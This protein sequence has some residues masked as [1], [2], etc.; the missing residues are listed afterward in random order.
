MS[1]AKELLEMLSYINEKSIRFKSAKLIN[2]L[3]K[4]D[5][6]ESKFLKDFGKKYTYFK[7]SYSE[8]KEG[9]E[10]FEEYRNFFRDTEKRRT[11]LLKSQLG[12]VQKEVSDVLSKK[13]VDIGDRLEKVEQLKSKLK[14]LISK[15]GPFDDGN[16]ERQILKDKYFDAYKELED[17][18]FNIKDLFLKEFKDEFSGKSLS[19]T[20]EMLRA[21]QN[22]GQNDLFR[23]VIKDK[24]GKEFPVYIERSDVKKLDLEV[25]SKVK[26]KLQIERGGYNSNEWNSLKS[27][28]ARTAVTIFLVDIKK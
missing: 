27:D 24:S 1:K 4:L 3:S 20:I 16:K 19:G 8:P 28:V 18:I 26:Y 5:K 7:D 17:Y 25:G 13:G 22:F 21:D 11:D 15:Y 12:V 2:G 14:P 9:D 6:E 23:A 10:G